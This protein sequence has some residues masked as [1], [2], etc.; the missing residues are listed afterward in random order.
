[1]LAGRE[2]KKG[3]VVPTDDELIRQAPRTIGLNEDDLD[4]LY[5]YKGRSKSPQVDFS[6]VSRE[7]WTTKRSPVINETFI[8]RELDLSKPRLQGDVVSTKQLDLFQV[9]ARKSRVE[10]NS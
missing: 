6:E 10:N 2:A 5:R 8:Q 7:I 4:D 1:M 9:E 3:V